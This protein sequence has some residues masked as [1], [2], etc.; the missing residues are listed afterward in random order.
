MSSEKE[1]NIAEE[2]ADRIVQL[3]GIAQEES[4]CEHLPNEDFLCCNCQ[5]E[6]FTREIL[7]AIEVYKTIP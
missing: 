5:L 1:L 4:G 7:R 6:I 3:L 2:A